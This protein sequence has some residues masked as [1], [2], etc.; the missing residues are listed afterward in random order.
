MAIQKRYDA[1]GKV[2]TGGLPASE[3]QSLIVSV[4][5]SDETT[6]CKHIPDGN[7]NTPW[8]KPCTDNHFPS[9]WR[10]TKHEPD[11]TCPGHI[12]TEDGFGESQLGPFSTGINV[13]A[14]VLRAE[15]DSFFARSGGY[16]GSW[17]DVSGAALDV[18][19]LRE[20]RAVEMEFFSKM[21]VWTEKLPKRAVK[22]RGGNHISGRWVDTNK[23]GAARP[24]YRARF[25]GKEFNTGVDPTLY[26]ATPPLEALKLLLAHASS[27]PG[28][29][30]HIMLSDAKRAYFYAMA[31]RELYV[32]LRREDP[33][34][35][36]KECMVG[37]LR[38]ALYGTRDAALPW[39]EC[40][41]EHLAECG[42]V[43][44]VL[45]PCV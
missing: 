10:D 13:G 4:N 41:A 7:V 1:S 27:C 44:G 22:S 25:V 29:R 37:R 17:D 30:A 21:G 16:T 6:S 39:Q 15:I 9:H 43:R 14:K 28:R 11:G 19:L 33:G 45:N 5:G 20:A 40:L 34:F 38:L 32:E 35:D 8:S 12:V 31:T 18:W 42:F 24:D 23:G 3:L 2:R 26:A 36:D